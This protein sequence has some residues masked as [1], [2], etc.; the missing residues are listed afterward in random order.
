MTLKSRSV[1]IAQA[2][3]TL[4]DN[5]TQEISPA[6][7]RNMFKDGFDSFISK[8]GDNGI[9]A[10]IQYANAF[11][12]T[13]GKQLVYADWVIAQI[14]SITGFHYYKGDPLSPAEGDIRE[15]YESTTSNIEL[16]EYKSGAWTTGDAARSSR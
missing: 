4:S 14:N 1:L 16:Q 10:I 5:E 9:L 7:V 11:S 12:I 2:N 6:D 8:N 13:D 15:G 3:L